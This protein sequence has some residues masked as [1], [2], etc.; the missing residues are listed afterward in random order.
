[1]KTAQNAPKQPAKI[2]LIRLSA[3]GDIVQ[4]AIVAYFV[5]KNLPNSN[6]TWFCDEKF[7]AIARLCCGVDEVV[8]LPLKAKKFAKS[9][10]IVRQRRGEF[11]S[12]IDLQGLLKSAVVARIL[13]PN[14]SGFSP[15]STKEFAA[16]LL[17][18]QKTQILYNENIII[19]NLTLASKALN[20]AWSR[21]EILAKPALFKA[22]GSEFESGVLVAPFSSQASKNYTHFDEVI[23]LVKESFKGEIYICAGS[24]KEREEA[25]KLAQK[26][27]AKLLPPLDLTQMT[28][29]V[30]HAKLVIG[31]DSGITHLAWAQNTKSITLFGNR[32]SARNAYA[33]PQNIV[34]DAGKKIDARRIDESDFCINQICPK[35]V[36]K[37]ALELLEKGEGDA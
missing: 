24:Q 1:M 6:L 18:A 7:G 19:R 23:A 32:P 9:W 26:S 13:A 16:G 15:K 8:E 17:Y 37:R 34:L 2:A 22:F 14:P 4:S 28:N 5:K 21:E 33:T 35:L 10:E 12:V 20:F 30:S 29:L 31:N 11:D 25:Q 27:G 36:A 3:L